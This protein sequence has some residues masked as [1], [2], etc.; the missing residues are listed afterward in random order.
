MLVVTAAVELEGVTSLA[1]RTPMEFK[2]A[3]E[4]P[5]DDEAFLLCNDAEDFSLRAM[6]ANKQPRALSLGATSHF[7][8]IIPPKRMLWGR[9]SEGGTGG[10][11]SPRYRPARA[12]PRRSGR[13]A[14]SEVLEA[15]RPILQTT[16]ASEGSEPLGPR[17]RVG[18][19]DGALRARR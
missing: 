17:P 2:S 15:G 13:R 1:H 5:D 8:R 18:R 3:A 14:E 16:P 7:R 11:S 4:L 10:S 9:E 19:P 6:K 12:T